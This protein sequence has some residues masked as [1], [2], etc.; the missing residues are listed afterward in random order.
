MPRGREKGSTFKILH[1]P[2]GDSLKIRKF[3]MQESHW[4]WLKEKGNGNASEALRRL[5]KHAIWEEEEQRSKE[6][7]REA[8]DLDI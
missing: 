6:L 4:Q 3:H 5:I 1:I 8:R 2:E 7:R